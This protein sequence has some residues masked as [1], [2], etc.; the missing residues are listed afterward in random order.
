MVNFSIGKSFLFIK[1]SKNQKIKKKPIPFTVW[2]SSNQNAES[3]AQKTTF[4]AS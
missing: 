2:A 4:C 1:Q 3:S